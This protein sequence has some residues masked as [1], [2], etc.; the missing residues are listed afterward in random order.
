MELAQIH[1]GKAF[2][3]HTLE[4]YMKIR[5]LEMLPWSSHT[6]PTVLVRLDL[7]VPMQDGK[8]TDTTRITAVVPTLKVLMEKKAK[9]V[10]CSHLGRPK[11][12][13][14]DPST[15]LAEAGSILANLL[16]AEVLLCPDYLEDGI[17]K[18]ISD[19]KENQIVLLENLRYHPEEQA[20]DVNFAKKLASLA[21]FYVNDAFGTSHRPDA[22]I[23]AVALQFEES[24]RAA[25]LLIQK[26]IN[27][28]MGALAQPK[29]P[30][31]AIFGGSKV[32]DKIEILMKFTQIANNILVGGAMAYTF[33]KETGVDVGNSRVETE[34]LPLVREI[35][36]AAEARKVKVILPVDH[37]G[38]AQFDKSAIPV[39]V[40]QASIPGHLMGLDI[41]PKTRQLFAQ[42]IQDSQVVVWNGPMG[43]FEWPAFESGTKSVAEAMSRCPGVTIVGG[44]DSAAAITQFGLENK[45]SHVS[46]G[47]GASLELMEGKELPGLKVLKCF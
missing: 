12:N 37:V 31:T 17:K 8:V 20:G 46:T 3:L 10:V 7:N 26:E 42:V 18:I 9:V 30:V 36:R 24:C 29:P 43:V 40:D 32:S 2:D 21:D 4:I 45:V 19:L 38:A 11:G 25:G 1:L 6:K 14:N 35:L 34:K 15:S 47:G 27:Y 16:G 22:S 28:L 23:F 13:T 44:G 39:A 5:S 33:L 41:G